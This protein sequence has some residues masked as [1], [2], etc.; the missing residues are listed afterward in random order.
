MALVLFIVRQ[1]CPALAEYASKHERSKV[2]FLEQYL[3]CEQEERR[4]Q[5]QIVLTKLASFANIKTLEIHKFKFVTG[6]TKKTMQILMSLAF[7]KWHDT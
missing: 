2:D 4:K 7:V 3:V 6:A 1:H 5:A